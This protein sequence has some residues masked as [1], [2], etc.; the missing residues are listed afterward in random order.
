MLRDSH[1]S[2]ADR[3][4]PGM[5]QSERVLLYALYLLILSA[6]FV[7]FSHASLAQ[8]AKE[9][10]IRLAVVV[11]FAAAT[12]RVIKMGA[13][14]PYRITE[15]PPQT[16]ANEGVLR[17]ESQ[18]ASEVSQPQ[19]PP[20]RRRP[21]LVF[22]ILVLAIYFVTSTSW[23]G[24]QPWTNRLMDT[25]IQWA[26]CLLCWGFLLLLWMPK[27]DADQPEAYHVVPSDNANANAPKSAS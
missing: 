13:V 7:P 19:L 15:T 6:L 4:K 24:R 14:E 12:L 18:E 11:A 8:F 17:V 10:L 20:K 2:A 27:P 3:E 5:K 22:W 16:L 26:I 25:A 1:L 9:L 21:L 23:W